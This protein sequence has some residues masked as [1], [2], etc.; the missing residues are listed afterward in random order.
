MIATVVQKTAGSTLGTLGVLR[1]PVTTKTALS[2]GPKGDYQSR[3]ES[4]WHTLRQHGWHFAE[5]GREPVNNSAEAERT[6]PVMVSWCFIV[7]KEGP[8]SL[9]YSA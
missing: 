7:R 5:T 3:E 4:G 2:T 6:R 1:N 9:N 8:P